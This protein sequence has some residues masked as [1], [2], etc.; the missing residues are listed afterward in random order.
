MCQLVPRKNETGYAPPA[1]EARLR[2]DYLKAGKTQTVIV[3]SCLARSMT[4]GE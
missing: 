3:C 1:P 4:I 2:S